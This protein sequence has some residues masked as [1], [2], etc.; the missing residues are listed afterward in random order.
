VFATTS[1]VSPMEGAVAHSKLADLRPLAE[2][3]RKQLEMAAATRT[4][5]LAGAR[6][7]FSR[8]QEGPPHSRAVFLCPDKMSGEMLQSQAVPSKLEV[9][10]TASAEEAVAM[11]MEMPRGGRSLVIVD[12]RM[13]GAALDRLWSVSSSYGVLMAVYGSADRGPHGEAVV[14]RSLGA[15]DALRAIIDLLEKEG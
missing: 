12:D 3:L 9:A 15:G 10:P 4:K 2:S 11:V 1:G 5:Q 6:H 14:K 8:R 7:M 13:G